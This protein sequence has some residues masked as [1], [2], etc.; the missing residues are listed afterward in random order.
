MKKA[1][2]ADD[3]KLCAEII[4]HLI[5]KC[6]LP[7]EIIGKAYSGDSALNMILEMRPDIV[8]MD[9]R[10]PVMS[11]LEVIKKAQAEEKNNTEFIVVTAYN[12]FE[13]AQTALRLGAKDI[14]LKPVDHEKFTEAVKRV[15]GYK[16]T[17]NQLMNEMADYI[18]KNYAKELTLNGFSEEFYLSPAHITRLFKKY[19]GLSFIAY[20]NSIRIKRSQRLLLDSEHSINAISEM[21]GYQNSNYFYRK[22]KEFTGVTPG[23]YKVKK[24]V[25]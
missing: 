2:I 23:E 20:L 17:P 7:I 9:V 10:M 25:F 15:I 13:Y 3:E 4:E 22:F 11:G 19:M 12:Y 5:Q 18:D 1:L 14:I 16:Y 24:D 6:E 21:V 8:F